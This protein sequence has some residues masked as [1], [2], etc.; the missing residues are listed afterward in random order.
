MRKIIRTA[1]LIAVFAFTSTLLLAQEETFTPSTP[2]WISDKGYWIIESNIKSPDTATVH[3]Y[4]NDNVRIYSEKVEG[5]TLNLK[6]RKTLMGLKKV[7][8]Q[9]LL[10]WQESHVSKDNAQ[11]VSNILIRKTKGW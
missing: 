9:S 11:L 8:E 1:I 2:R 4:N 5:I 6:K 3:F 10:A 7:L